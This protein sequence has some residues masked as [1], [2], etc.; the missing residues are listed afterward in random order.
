MGE[1]PTN[2]SNIRD[3][4]PR[5]VQWWTSV[6]DG[7]PTLNQPWVNVSGGAYKIPT[8]LPLT[9]RGSTLVVRI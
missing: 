8:I 2:R 1:N 4:H 5:L 6:V 9:E 7:G 3:I